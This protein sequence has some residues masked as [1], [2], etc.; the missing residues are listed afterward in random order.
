MAW[1]IETTAEDMTDV[2]E[3]HIPRLDIKVQRL[4]AIT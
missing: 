4:L 1:S 3:Y 2:A